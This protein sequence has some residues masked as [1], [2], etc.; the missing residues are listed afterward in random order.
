MAP[1]DYDRNTLAEI[2]NMLQEKKETVRASAEITQSLRSKNPSAR[3]PSSMY[4]GE[5]DTGL[6]FASDAIS[7]IAP[8]E[9]EFTFDDTV[10]NSH[11]YRRVLAQA[12][13]RIQ[14]PDQ[15]ATGNPADMPDSLTVRQNHPGVLMNTTEGRRQSS[16]VSA[17]QNASSRPVFGLTLSVLYERDKLAVPVIVHQCIKGVDLYGLQ[18]EGI[19]LKSGSVHNVNIL[20]N[21]FN[22]A[23]IDFLN[24]ENLGLS[25]YDVADLLKSFLLSL[26]EPLVPKYQA[27]ALV[28]AARFDDDDIRRDTLHAIINTLPDPNYAVL[29][30]LTLHLSRVIDHSQVNKMTAWNLAVV[31]APT[32]MGPTTDD[33]DILIAE[34]QIRA[35]RTILLFPYWI[36][37]GDDGQ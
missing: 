4:D 6:P 18:V 35:V 12:Q 16:S 31:F 36:F 1:A 29:R 25:I 9:I 8:S 21:H 3:V 33:S 2:K 30:A 32:L 28:S 23:P 34:W 20:R 13:A 11:A 19:Y 24:S 17:P 15:Q 37:V 10:I 7:V 26:P 14:A 22:M 5:N 27:D